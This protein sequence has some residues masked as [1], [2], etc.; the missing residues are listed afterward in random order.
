[1]EAVRDK[2][3]RQEVETVWII[4][5]LSPEKADA[6]RLQEDARQ[7]WNLFGHISRL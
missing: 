6:T 5:S 3:G 2:S 1:M 7:Y 4:P